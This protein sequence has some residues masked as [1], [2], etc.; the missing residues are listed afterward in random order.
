M[1]TILEPFHR[2]TLEVE[3]ARGNGALYDMLPTMHL[4][5][6]HL[7]NAKAMHSAQP[8]THFLQSFELAWQKLNKYYSMKESNSVLYAA[9]DLLP[10]MKFEYFKINWAEHPEWI[11][12]VRSKV[13]DIWERKY[14]L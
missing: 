6:E 1:V 7:K 12:D 3:G 5:L 10:G 4:L 14:V 8:D 13:I 2:C 11:K 9:V